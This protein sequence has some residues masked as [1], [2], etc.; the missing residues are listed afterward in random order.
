M[1]VIYFLIFAVYPYSRL[2]SCTSSGERFMLI[3]EACYFSKSSSVV[4][5]SQLE[6]TRFYGYSKY[7]ET[8]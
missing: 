7:F 5:M 1:I 4:Y 3:L 2:P 8:I 6:S